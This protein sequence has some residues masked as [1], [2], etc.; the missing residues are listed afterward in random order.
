MNLQYSHFMLFH[1]NIIA[2]LT[3]NGSFPQFDEDIEIPMPLFVWKNQLINI[4]IR[5]RNIWNMYLI[6][7]I[8][9]LL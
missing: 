1:N 6:M 8:F 4:K 2:I 5:T 9:V 7:T 3:C